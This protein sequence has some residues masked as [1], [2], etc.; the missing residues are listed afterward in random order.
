M[1]SHSITRRKFLKRSIL[2]LSAVQLNRCSRSHDAKGINKNRPNIIFILTDDQRWDAVGCAGNPIIQTPNMDRLAENGTWFERAFITTPICA[3]SRASFFTGL[4]ERKH[5]YSFGTPPLSRACTD[6]S[7]PKLL[8]QNGY[9]S[10]FFGKFGIEVE[11]GAVENMFDE[12]ENLFRDPYFKN[13]DGVERHLTDI[14]GDKAIQFLRDNPQNIPF[15]LSVSFNAPHAED[16]DPRQYIWPHACDELYKDIVIPPPD[17]ADPSFFEKL[18]EYL[19]T[20][21][22]RERWKWRFDTPEK[23]QEMVKGYYRMISGIDMVIGRLT[24]ELA[25]LNLDSNTIIVLMGDNGYFL[26]ERG[27][28][29]K[30]LMYD[31]SIRVPLIVYDPRMPSSKRDRVLNQMALNVDLAP[32]FLEYA[33]VEVPAAMHGESLV[34]LLNGEQVGWRSEVFCEHLCKL[35]PT[36]PQNEGIRTDRW[37][38]LR[39]REYPDSE[40][41]YDLAADPPEEINLAEN[42]RYVQQL[43][44][45]RRRCDEM[46]AQYSR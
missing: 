5:G 25:R 41:L 10:G 22:N 45:L 33:G 16:N 31:D 26:G 6:I 21:M 35:F 23:Y 2:G 36:I 37:K 44:E 3:A 30:W 13:V 27:F 15:C 38:Y 28:A 24:E 4:Y 17:T 46:I 43:S 20:S 19:K 12:Y 42:S 40:E 34:P 14:I 1:K 7:Y 18:P 29:G 9:R 11:D 8:K 39:Y 32:T